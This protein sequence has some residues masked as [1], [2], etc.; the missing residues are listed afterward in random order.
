M[1]SYKLLSWIFLPFI[2][3][4]C[5]GWLDVK[6]EDEID[7][8]D[9]FETGIGYRHAL[10]GVYFALG[11]IDLYGK[12][13]SWGIVDALGQCYTY[14]TAGNGA[15]EMHYGASLYDWDHQYMEPCIESIWKKTYNAVANCNN[16]IQN[17]ANENP[18]KFDYKER[19]KSMIWGEALALRAYLQ[20]D[21]L[22]L[23]AP[24]PSTNPGSRTF[25]PYVSEYPVYVSKA[26]SVD[27]CLNNVI[28]DLKEAKDLV[29]EADSGRSCRT[30][31]FW[32]G[33]QSDM[34]LFY[35]SKRGFRLNYYA[36]SAVLAR[37]Y[38]YAQQTENAYKEAK[39]LIDFAEGNRV[40]EI[41]YYNME[42]YGDFKSYADMLWGLEVVDL[43]DFETAVNTVDNSDNPLYIGVAGA[44]INFWGDDIQSGSEETCNDLRFVNWVTHLDDYYGTYKFTKYAQRFATNNG[45]QIGNTLVPMIRMSEMYYIAAE[46]IYKTD[47]A[48]AKEYLLTVKEGRG[49]SSSDQSVRNVNMANENNFLNILQND[50]RREWLGEGQ[51]FYMYKR[52]NQNIPTVDQNNPKEE[53]YEEIKAEEKNF[54]IPVPNIE[55][56]L[57]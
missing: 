51:I 56:D 40:F 55:T 5:N 33:G 46:A 10:N 13:L 19:E 49:L 1:K 7:E 52:L 23:F 26:L 41:D 31:N 18:E 34:G 15:K 20:F 36:I 3:Y 57:M 35:E 4:A 30:L 32:E 21:M 39:A 44:K 28:R 27:S 42:Y 16:I 25:I 45:T 38:M 11:D 8:K 2:A 48:E 6:P 43:L 9:L 22:R 12:H 50:A 47:L 14:I 17:I 53:S 37:V 29:W 54:V 24:A